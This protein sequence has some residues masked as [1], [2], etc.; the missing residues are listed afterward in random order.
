MSQ[1]NIPHSNTVRYV[2][3]Q[4]VLPTPPSG[5]AEVKRLKQ[6][7]RARQKSKLVDTIVPLCSPPPEFLVTDAF[8]IFSEGWWKCTYA[9]CPVGAHDLGERFCPIFVSDGKYLPD[10]RKE[11]ERDP[12]EL[13]EGWWCCPNRKCEMR[14][15][16]PLC[17]EKR[18]CG[19]EDN[20]GRDALIKE[21]EE[22]RPTSSSENN[23]EKWIAQLSE[24]SAEEEIDVMEGGLEPGLEY[25]YEVQEPTSSGPVKLLSL[26]LPRRLGVW[27]LSLRDKPSGSK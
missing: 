16:R 14:S 24:L 5:P 10:G 11:G 13:Q 17:D 3:N 23:V 1:H 27:E 7:D 21:R 9:G 12:I 4:N 20:Y 18:T 2:N 26:R 22:M 8:M 15:R 19:C 6:V 25:A